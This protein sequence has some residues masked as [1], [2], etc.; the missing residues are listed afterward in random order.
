[1]QKAPA[2]SDAAFAAR[3][4][5]GGQTL[6]AIPASHSFWCSVFRSLDGTG[7]TLERH[8]TRDSAPV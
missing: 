6:D 1:M 5:L 2:R 3:R 4:S 7:Q 8:P